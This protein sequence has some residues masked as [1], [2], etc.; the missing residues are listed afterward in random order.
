MGSGITTSMR[1]PEQIADTV[2]LVHETNLH[3]YTNKGRELE[4]ILKSDRSTSAFLKYLD[5]NDGKG[6][7]LI[8]FFSWLQLSTKERMNTY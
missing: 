5:R 6:C 4:R 3:S 1:T 7:C 8:L 2:K